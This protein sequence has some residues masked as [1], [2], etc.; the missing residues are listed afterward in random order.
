MASKDVTYQKLSNLVVFQIAFRTREEFFF[1]TQAY[2]ARFSTLIA[3]YGISLTPDAVRGFTRLFPG[4]VDIDTRR[5][6]FM[7][8]LDVCKNTWGGQVD[9][10]SLNRVLEMFSDKGTGF[11]L[12]R[13]PVRP[14]TWRSPGGIVY[15][16]DAA[17]TKPI[18]GHRILHLLAHSVDGYLG[19]PKH[20]VFNVAREEIPALLDEA[21]AKKPAAI[22]QPNGNYSYRVPMGK[23]IGTLGERTIEIIVKPGTNGASDIIV[24]AFLWP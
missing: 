2:Y 15:V 5:D 24:T 22:L 17:K 11:R 3:R 12:I 1:L 7:R 16:L 21:W 10:A 4:I 13:D 23:D 14:T 6:Y 20:T 19:K 9:A 18:E 8:L